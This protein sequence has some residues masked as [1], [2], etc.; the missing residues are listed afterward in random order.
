MKPHSTSKTRV[1]ALLLALVM[2]LG[3]TA[4]GGT[5]S[6]IVDPE[7][8]I[9]TDIP[10]PD[11]NNKP[12]VDLGGWG[13]TTGG[14][15]DGKGATDGSKSTTGSK[16]D[17]HVPGT[18]RECKPLNKGELGVVTK[19]YSDG[20]L[21]TL[22]KSVKTPSKYDGKTSSNDTNY[23]KVDWSTA[24]QGYISFTAKGQERCFILEGPNGKQTIC[25][26][27]K[28]GI[29]KIALIDGTGKYQYAIAN[30][31]NNGKNYRIQYKNSFAVSKIDSD[32][33]PYLVSTPYGDY[34]NAPNAVAKADKLWDTN[35]SQLK[36]VQEITYYVTST[37]HYD[38][39]LKMGT[40]DIPINP[41]KVIENG[42]GVCNE[43]SKT[44]VAM[45]RSQG[46]PAYVQGGTNAKGQ[47]HA[48]V[49]AW[50]EASSETKNGTTYSTGTWILIEATGG[51]LQAKSTADKNYT[52]D[53]YAG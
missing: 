2:V 26:V 42:G 5:G 17:A 39:K 50:L 45:L 18:P 34:A 47:G 13:K 16:A 22:V 32:L 6:V 25:T 43:M 33:A 8:G 27:A 21:T 30:N 29:I 15:S 24:N 11:A 31:T 37:L 12:W 35:K 10:D 52:P 14:K 53:Q 9:V 19:S 49:M 38:K 40:M 48:W 51:G 4:C 7:T 41:D 3:L 20:K 36:N 1:A 28:D 23:G 46:I 44:L